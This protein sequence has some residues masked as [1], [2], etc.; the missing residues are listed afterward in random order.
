MYSV[1]SRLAPKDVGAYKVVFA[2][3][4]NASDE[5]D[6]VRLG[7]PLTVM[8]WKINFSFIK[9]KQRVGDFV[10]VKEDDMLSDGPLGDGWVFGTSWLT[11]CSGF[12][13]K[14]YV[15]K[16]PEPN[17]WTLHLSLPLGKVIQKK[18]CCKG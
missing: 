13:P 3:L 18:I 6:L 2:H 17:A 8:S 12:M 10:Y 15:A 4:P 1:D 11:G 14:N 7:N 5:L 16:T 9:L